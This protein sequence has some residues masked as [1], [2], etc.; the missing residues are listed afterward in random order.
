LR[1]LPSSFQTTS[2]AFAPFRASCSKSLQ[3]QIRL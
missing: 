2:E 3:N 1:S